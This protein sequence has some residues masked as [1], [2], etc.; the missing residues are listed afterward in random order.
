MQIQG[1]KTEDMSKMILTL[2]LSAQTLSF[3]QKL[4]KP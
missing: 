1:T 2:K 3:T 4:T